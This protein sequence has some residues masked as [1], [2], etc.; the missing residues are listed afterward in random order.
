MADAMD[1]VPASGV[2]IQ[3]ASL[4]SDLAAWYW[5][6]LPNR[7]HWSWGWCVADAVVYSVVGLHCVKD[8]LI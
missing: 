5:L 2:V 8:R 7:E 1:V 3:A 4:F 6:E